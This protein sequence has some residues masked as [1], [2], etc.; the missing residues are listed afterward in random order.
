MAGEFAGGG[1]A[2]VVVQR[3]VTTNKTMAGK[4]VIIFMM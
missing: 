2:A 4:N 3:V 1:S